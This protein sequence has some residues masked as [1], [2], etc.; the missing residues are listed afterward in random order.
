M[1]VGQAGIGKTSLVQEIYQ[2]ITRRRGYFVAGKFDQLQQNVPFS[3]LVTALQDLVQQ[4]LTESEEEIAA[5]RRRSRRRP[6]ERP[7]DLDV[8][9]A[10]ELI[11][12]KQPRVP[13][14]EAFEA[15]N[16]FNLAF[17]NFVQVFCKRVAPARA[18]SRRH[19]VGRLGEPESRHA[20]RVGARDRVAAARHDLSR[21]RGHSQPSVHAGRE[22][23][24]EA[25]R[26]GAC[27]RARAARRTR[28]GRVR[29]RHVA[30]GCR[31]GDAV[32]GDHPAE[33]GRQSVLHAPIR[34]RS[35]CRT[36]HHVRRGDEALPLRRFSRQERGDH[37][38]RGR[39]SG[40]RAEA[41]AR[42]HARDFARRSH[43]RRPV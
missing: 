41:I 5:W 18:V 12:G 28:R 1:V 10:L 37:G 38:E 42:R 13:E 39:V 23:A 21:Q 22:G 33:D 9:P 16:R 30:S 17:Q 31:D 25:R 8:V 34:P 24:D 2:P 35:V 26:T 40:N 7:A 27:D 20:Y 4:L 6:S 36:A 43:H 32:G 29:R 3:A 11:I 15:Q 14:L 19:A